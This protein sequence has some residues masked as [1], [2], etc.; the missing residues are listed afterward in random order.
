MAEGTVMRGTWY[1]QA[2]FWCALGLFLVWDWQHSPKPN[3]RLEPPLIAAGSGQ[4][5]SGAHCAVL[6]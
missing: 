5:P 4:A 1:R 2:V 3:V 6:K